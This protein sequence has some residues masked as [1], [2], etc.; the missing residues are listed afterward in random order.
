[1]LPGSVV[2]HTRRRRVALRGTEYHSTGILS[3]PGVGDVSLED[4]RAI[5]AEW[6]ASGLAERSLTPEGLAEVS[7]VAKSTVYRL[8]KAE[9]TVEESTLAALSKALKKP[10][11]RLVRAPDGS[12]IKS[13][14]AGSGRPQAGRGGQGQARGASGN[15]YS[16]PLTRVSESKAPPLALVEP[17]V[18]GQDYPIRPD[19]EETA[20]MGG[21]AVQRALREVQSNLKSRQDRIIMAEE[22]EAFAKQLR[23]RLGF[24]DTA[25]D[26]LQAALNL[27]K[28]PPDHP[29]RGGKS[30]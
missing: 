27:R 17:I 23:K 15:A 11:P 19:Q 22:L 25:N 8:L 14:V 6:I 1:M 28:E 18:T 13:D 5:T 10:F 21:N 24:A 2:S 4:L 20:S 30:I 9:V 7:G 29:T 16:A 12:P 26:L 3:T